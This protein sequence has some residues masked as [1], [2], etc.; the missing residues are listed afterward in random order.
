MRAGAHVEG[1]RVL[2]EDEN[3]GLGGRVT[4]SISVAVAW[5]PTDASSDRPK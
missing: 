3:L 1:S 2:G 5:H 4:N